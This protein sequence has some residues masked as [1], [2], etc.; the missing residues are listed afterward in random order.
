M[1][2]ESFFLGG[3]ECCSHRRFDGRGLDP[4]ESTGHGAA[5]A[6]DYRLLRKHG[7]LAARD[8]VLPRATACVG[9]SSSAVR[10]IRLVELHADTRAAAD[11]RV[12]VVGDLCHYGCPDHLDIW[13]DDF[14]HSFAAFATECTRLIRSRSQRAAMLCI[15]NEISFWSW[16]GGDVAC[17][18]PLASERGPALPI[19]AVRTR[20][21]RLRQDDSSITMAA[22]PWKRKNGRA[23]S[24]E[25]APHPARGRHRSHCCARFAV[26]F[27]TCGS[28]LDTL[29][30]VEGVDRRNGH[31]LW[32]SSVSLER[33]EIATIGLLSR[34]EK[35]AADFIRSKGPKYNSVQ[36]PAASILRHKRRA[37]AHR[38]PIRLQNST[39]R[40]LGCDRAGELGESVKKQH[41]ECALWRAGSSRSCES[42]RACRRAAPLSQYVREEFSDVAGHER[43]FP[44][45]H[46]LIGLGHR[47][48]IVAGREYERNVSMIQ[49]VG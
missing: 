28:I 11:A 10:E 47:F 43:L 33:T 8:G 2:F 17:I 36:S 18:N 5:A 6:R 21:S 37:V 14:V 9:I 41:H 35:R 30:S 49:N 12:A 34:A 26:T 4:I 48:L 46:A 3:F 15:V 16:A 45:W 25:C 1:P 39:C 29:L 24:D 44:T 31:R 42:G 32:P 38:R 40:D 20:H 19:A 7:V 22:P 13:A 23:T 27:I